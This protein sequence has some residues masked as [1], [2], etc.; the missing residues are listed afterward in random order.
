MNVGQK[1][2]NIMVSQA[3]SQ[4]H[5]AVMC[6]D[7]KHLIEDNLEFKNNLAT[8]KKDYYETKRTVE[9]HTI[10]FSI[11]HFFTV[12]LIGWLGFKN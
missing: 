2:D 3:E 9:K 8:L 5:Q 10:W 11:I 7:L 1:L 4:K 6:N 12:S